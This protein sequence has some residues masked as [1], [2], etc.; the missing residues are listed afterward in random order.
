MG[1]IIRLEFKKLI[2][3]KASAVYIIGYC[4]ICG[5]FIPYFFNQEFNALII[6]LIFSVITQI[7]PGVFAN[8]RE[9]KTFETLISMPIS[10]NEIFLSKATYCFIT[11][12]TMLY[13][14]YLLN[15]GMSFI[16]SNPF[17]KHFKI[18]NMIIYFLMLPISIFNLSY[19]ATYISFRSNDSKACAIKTIYISVPYYVISI[20]LIEVARIAKKGFIVAIISYILINIVI[21]LI[22]NF[23]VKKYFDKSKILELLGGI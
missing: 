6:I 21:F 11:I 12:V 20:A 13:I 16:V 15:Y 9:D 22:L 5:I 23:K 17:I 3:N 4:F 18:E 10:M 14:T 7:S 2:S 19:H 1:Q 8:E